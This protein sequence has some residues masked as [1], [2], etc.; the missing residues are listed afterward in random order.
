MSLMNLPLYVCVWPSTFL[1]V[2]GA[3]LVDGG[4]VKRHP[5][6]G[7][8][9]RQ[10]VIRVSMTAG[11]GQ[12]FAALE[13]DGDVWRR[14]EKRL[15]CTLVSNQKCSY[16]SYIHTAMLYISQHRHLN[17]WIIL[18]NVKLS[19]VYPS[20]RLLPVTTVYISTKNSII[21]SI[22]N[23]TSWCLNL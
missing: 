22:K 7:D 17:D 18:E 12:W 13:S 6:S 10:E 14:R 15:Y 2:F 4:L 21:Y 16:I 1:L 11:S 3:L 5:S 8:R 23:K 9:R 20:I 19:D